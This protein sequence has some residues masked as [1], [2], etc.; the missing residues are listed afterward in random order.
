MQQNPQSVVYG[1]GGH[2]LPGSFFTHIIKDYEFA[3]RKFRIIQTERG[4]LA[5]YIQPGLR[6]NHKV[7]QQLIN[8]IKHFLG[9]STEITISLKD[10]LEGKVVESLIKQESME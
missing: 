7:E 3:I 10:K 4:K 9:P 2:F 1:H 8:K 5:L 6:Y